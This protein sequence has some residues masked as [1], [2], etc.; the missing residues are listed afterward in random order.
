MIRCPKCNKELED[1]SLFCDECGSPVGEPAPQETAPAGNGAAFG[2]TA[3]IGG[4]APAS[5]TASIGGAAPASETAPIGGAAPAGGTAPIGGAAPAGQKVCPVCGRLLPADALFCDGCGANMGVSPAATEAPGADGKSG[6]KGKGKAIYLILAAAVVLCVAVVAVL[7]FGL[8]GKGGRGTDYAMYIKEKE[9]FYSDLKKKGEQITDDLVDEGDISNADFAGNAYSI[10][11]YVVRSED[12]SKL[13]YPDM[14]SEKDNGFT[15]YWNRVDRSGD[16]AHKIDSD[17]LEYRVDD[18]ASYVIYRKDGDKLYSYSL[19]KQDKE[20]IASDVM[21]FA[22]S[23][24][25]KTVY[26]VLN[27]GTVYLWTRSGG[28][29]RVDSDVHHVEA[30]SEDFRTVYYIKED[31]LYQKKIGKD[32]EKIDSDVTRVLR[33]YDSDHI[34][35]LKDWDELTADM[36]IVDDKKDEDENLQEPS[37]YFSITPEEQEAYEAKRRRNDLR[38]DLE[39][40]FE[41]NR[42]SSLS[43]LCYYDGRDKEEILEGVMSANVAVKGEAVLVAALDQDNMEP[44]KL[45]RVEQDDIWI[46]SAV[47][48]V[49]RESCVY[50]L[51]EGAKTIDLDIDPEENIYDCSIDSDGNRILYLTDYDGEKDEGDLYQI[52]VKNG[53]AS[54]SELV[55]SDAYAYRFGFTEDSCL[56][57]E[58]V[59]DGEGDLY[60]G[61]ESVAYDV[62]VY[63]GVTEDSGDCYYLTDYN[64]DKQRGTLYRYSGGKSVKI[65]D[66]VHRYDTLGDGRVLILN[67][68]SMDSYRGQLCLY[69]GK[70]L[71][72][73]D[74]DVVCILQQAGQSASLYNWY[75]QESASEET[76]SY[77]PQRPAA[78]SVEASS[79][80]PARL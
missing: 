17:V 22:A 32:R 74:D 54:E 67:D 31:N 36:V 1:G 16:E 55:A 75:K 28:S 35:Y 13:F 52:T 11:Q 64:S 65:A 50:T 62:Y 25:G 19:K 59:K 42:Y 12:G 6:K 3:P 37:S 33:V 20:K 45:S 58:D 43:V 46:G 63:L 73:L 9:L 4:A 5:E 60:I 61:D 2:G 80:A 27:D 70:K 69:S 44:K 23:D 18:K 29:E 10:S 71:E 77:E 78:E 76:A 41:E 66:D 30:L 26:Y 47:D 8:M 53:K 15:L 56:Y 79:E 57:Y 21:G 34:Y 49:L 38:E 40:Y 24:D 7:A 14:L 48:E 68:Y 51:A 72:T 39:E